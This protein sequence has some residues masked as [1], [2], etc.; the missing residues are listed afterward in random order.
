LLLYILFSILDLTPPTINCP[1]SIFAETELGQ[2]YKEISWAEPTIIDNSLT[3]SDDITVSHSPANIKAPYKFPIG[4]TIV[5]YMASDAVGNSDECVFR[6]E[7]IG[8][9][10]LDNN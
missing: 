4:V 3:G 5:K 6:V 9:I 7:V 2:A 8:K 10:H 1:E